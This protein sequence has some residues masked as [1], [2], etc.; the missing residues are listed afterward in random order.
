[1]S[2]VTICIPTY[3][4]TRWLA[5]SI[6]SAL[7]QTFPDLVIEVHDDATPDDSV[8]EVVEAFDDPRLRLIRHVDNAGIVGNFSRSLLGV[9]TDYVLQLGDDDVA[10]PTLVERT[11]SALDA[12]PSAGFAHSRFALIDAEGTVLED[13]DWLGE[14]SPPLETGAAFVEKSMAH[15]R[16]CSSTAMIRRSAVPEGGFR[17][18]DY[19]AFDLACWLRMSEHWDVAW[20]D[21]VLCRYRIHTESF[22]SGLCDL[23]DEG[24][25]QAEEALR[26]AH[27]VKRRHA[28]TLNPGPRRSHLEQ[29]ADR[30]LRKDLVGRVRAQTM[31]E[32]RF[33]A[34]LRGLMQLVRREPRSVLE[35]NAWKLL[36][37]SVVGPGAVERLRGSRVGQRMPRRG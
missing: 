11:V 27:T 29:L 23:T 2:R 1:M 20:I 14:P 9:S 24:Y 28:A 35:P 18:A 26:A 19:P 22:S 13:Q 25:R 15:N 30:G 8:V 16:V 3:K 37:G 17:Q 6:S 21:E 10:E 4:R 34:T 7:D 33:G 5:E 12:Y 32:R 36:A 31:P